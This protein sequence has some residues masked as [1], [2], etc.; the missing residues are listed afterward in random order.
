MKD[1]KLDEKGFARLENIPQ[2]PVQLYF[3]EDP[4]PYKMPSLPSPTKTTL[5][6]MQEEMLAHGYETDLEDIEPLLE[7]L[8]GRYF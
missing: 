8:A 3:G 1:G 2:G 4:Q 6:N 7:L 5:A